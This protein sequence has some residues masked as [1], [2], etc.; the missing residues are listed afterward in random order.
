[1]WFI[2]RTL[3]KHVCNLG[4]WVQIQ[5]SYLTV[6]SLFIFSSYNLNTVIVFF[7][8]NFYLILNV[9]FIFVIIFIII[10]S[11]CN[12]GWSEDL[13]PPQALEHRDDRNIVVLITPSPT[14]VLMCVYALC[15]LFLKLCSRLKPNCCLTKVKTEKT[16]FLP[17]PVF[18]PSS[19]SVLFCA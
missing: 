6:S 4:L 14:C 15:L 3:A 8:G 2:G 12:P 1:M 10:I 16:K 9:T 18:S 5:F 19:C 13:H 17:S 11:V 7:L